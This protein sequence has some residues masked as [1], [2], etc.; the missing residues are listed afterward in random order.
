MKKYYIQILSAIS[1]NIA[2]LQTFLSYANKFSFK[3]N[4][5]YR[6]IAVLN[7]ANNIHVIS[8]QAI[9]VLCT[10]TH[11]LILQTTLLIL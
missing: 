1:E 2:M 10:L 8:R 9:I 4:T 6:T 3:A 7:I 11:T 5:R